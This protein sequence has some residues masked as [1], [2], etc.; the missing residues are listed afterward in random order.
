MNWAIFGTTLALAGFILPLFTSAGQ[1][2]ANDTKAKLSAWLNNMGGVGKD[3]FNWATVFTEFFDNLY[4]HKLFSKRRV[5][6]SFITSIVLLIIIYIIWYLVSYDSL[7][8]SLE[9]LKVDPILWIIGIGAALNLIPDYFSL[10]ETRWI[11]K[12]LKRTSGILSVLF[13][14]ICDLVLTLLIFLVGMGVAVMIYE[15]GLEKELLLELAYILWGGLTIDSDYIFFSPFIYTT[16]FTSVWIYLYLI[17]S[18]LIKIGVL[19]GKGT[20]KVFGLLDVERKP[21]LSLGVVSSSFIFVIG[22]I[23]S[24]I[25]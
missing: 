6:M 7:N 9:G 15:G 21:F 5:F 1:A 22:I 11:L 23:F 17:S 2:A 13:L 3:P 10:Q 4:D 16:L 24:L 14:L 18:G 19:L 20:G 8:G 12:L 25:F